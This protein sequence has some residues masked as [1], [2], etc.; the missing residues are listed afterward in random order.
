[1]L[2]YS[3]DA[4]VNAEISEFIR[5]EELKVKLKAQVYL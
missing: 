1:M 3:I 2:G 5:D 4:E